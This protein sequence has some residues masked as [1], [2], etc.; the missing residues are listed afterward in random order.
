[1][2]LISFITDPAVVRKI[3]EHLGLSE[4]NRKDSRADTGM[5]ACGSRGRDLASHGSEATWEGPR[6]THRRAMS[7]GDSMEQG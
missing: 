7:A 6:P 5:A 2:K 1:M 3:L 4:K